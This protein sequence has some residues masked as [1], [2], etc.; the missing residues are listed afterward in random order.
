[1]QKSGEQFIHV[2]Y[3]EIFTLNLTFQ[4]RHHS[5]NYEAVNYCVNI[6]DISIFISISNYEFLKK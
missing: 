2:K 3:L 1:M 5:F 6:M 4:A